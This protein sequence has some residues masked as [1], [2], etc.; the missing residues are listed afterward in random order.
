MQPAA[1]N[2]KLGDDVVNFRPSST[3]VAGP[4]APSGAHLILPQSFTRF[5]LPPKR[6]QYE[7]FAFYPAES[8]KI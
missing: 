6:V 2:T 8:C 3:P 5:V 4:A 7:V 1:I